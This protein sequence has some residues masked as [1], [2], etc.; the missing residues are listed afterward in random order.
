MNMMNTQRVERTIG[1]IA[2]I[3][4]T[5]L[6]VAGLVASISAAGDG[7]AAQ[8]PPR[9]GR[10][11]PGGRSGPLGGGLLGRAG[12][13]LPGL[14]DAQ[15]SQI[16]S[17]AEQHRDELRRLAERAT[18]ARRQLRDSVIQG[19]VDEAKA[20]EV[21]AAAGAL[22]LA[23]AR[24]RSEIFALLTPEQR[25]QIDDRREQMQK[26]LAARPGGGPRGTGRTGGPGRRPAR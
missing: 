23:Q 11:G 6:L 13:N 8:G 4:C 21:G 25:Q 20:N 3:I 19:Q 26:W 15:R 9:A 12:L 16:R 22:A 14:S 18:T 10:Q 5:G 17:V 2:G 1:G 24:M 7:D